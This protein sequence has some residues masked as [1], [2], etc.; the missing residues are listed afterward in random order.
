MPQ[1]L[2][3]LS[4][5]SLE[6][7]SVIEDINKLKMFLDGS[8]LEPEHFD[9]LYDLDIGRLVTMQEEMAFIAQIKTAAHRIRFGHPEDD[10]N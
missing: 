9:Y 8:T 2:E 3:L 6:K 4:D 10:A 5:E 7:V 1:T